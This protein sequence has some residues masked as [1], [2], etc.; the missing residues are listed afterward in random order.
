VRERESVTPWAS[1]ARNDEKILVV[2][3]DTRIVDLLQITLSG[4]GFSVVT[5]VDGDEAMRRVELTRPDLVVLDTQLARKSG[6]KILEEIRCKPGYERLPVILISANVSSESKLEGLRLGAD[7]FVV[8]PFSPRELILRIRRILDRVG[9]SEALSRRIRE[10]EITLSRGEKA[11]EEARA[12]FRNRLFR[13]GSVVGALQRVGGARNVDELLSRFVTTVMSQLDI[14]AAALWILDESRRELTCRIARGW[15]GGLEAM[16]AI[17]PDSAL[18]E[19]LRDAR[20]A[21]SLASAESMPD[22]AAL[23]SRLRMTGLATACAV[24][25]GD[26]LV[27]VMALGDPRD[28]SLPSDVAA[29]VIVAL[30]DAIGAALETQGAAG[31]VRGALLRTTAVLVRNLEA[32]HTG[33]SGHSERVARYASALA[34]AA[35]VTPRQRGVI[36][37]AAELHDL[38]LVDLYERL[39]SLKGPLTE[40]DRRRIQ[41]APARAADM[42]SGAGELAEVAEII[43]HHHEH[44]DG[45][46]YPEGL[47]EESIPIGARIVAIANAFDALTHDRPHR[48]AQGL[49]EA[50]ATLEAE[51]DREFDPHLLEAFVRI[52]RVGAL[53]VA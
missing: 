10:L 48:P 45:T 7:D 9:E 34:E 14:A 21:L 4:R 22:T 15:P 25:R 41:G 11:L 49:D 38:G 29:D 12:E 1:R 23:A 51:A 33:L 6:L 5:A 2:D 16:P 39:G 18:A 37:L 17:P 24:R 43:R 31:A 35:G 8:K 3:A 42:V 26:D 20:R 13:I 47:A 27:A 19:T 52:A 30:A 53:P 50:L 36:E 32:R 40:A 44:W 46:G 28:R